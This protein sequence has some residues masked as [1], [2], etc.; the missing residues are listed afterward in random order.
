[1]GRWEK[2]AD[3]GPTAN[4]VITNSATGDGVC[5]ESGIEFA[6]GGQDPSGPTGWRIVLSVARLQ[7][8][9]YIRVCG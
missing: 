6:R 4:R 3:S 9:R 7:A 5:D 2:L 1:M 8:S